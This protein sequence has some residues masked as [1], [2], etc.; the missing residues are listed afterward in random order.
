LPKKD[1]LKSQFKDRPRKSIIYYWSLNDPDGF[2]K[3]L[4]ESRLDIQVVK[5][6]L[7]RLKSFSEHGLPKNNKEKFRHVEDKIC[8]LKPTS[9]VRLLGFEEGRDFI[10]LCMEIKKKDKLSP[11]LIDKAQRLWSTYN[12]Q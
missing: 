6:T 4:H 5:K 7:S 3:W 2:E 11:V 8:E 10:I 9:Q 12:A 1:I